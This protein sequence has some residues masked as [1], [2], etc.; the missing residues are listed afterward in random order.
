LKKID[1]GNT[2]GALSTNNVI[3]AMDNLSNFD[4]ES[5]GHQSLQSSPKKMLGRLRDAASLA[6]QVT[7]GRKL[8]LNK[9][10]TTANVITG[11]GYSMLDIFE[12]QFVDME[13]IV[14][15]NDEIEEV[16]S[17]Y[18]SPKKRR[19]GSLTKEE[20]KKNRREER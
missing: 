17:P 8:S 19:L 4:A 3:S 5:E 16:K 18:A 13:S 10:P 7:I 2:T 14:K 11:F 12:N 15:K 1:F 6:I 9:Q 20:Y